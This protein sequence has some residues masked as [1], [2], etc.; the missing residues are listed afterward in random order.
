MTRE[1]SLRNIENFS[2]QE[3]FDF[4]SEK[5]L[6]QG[7]RSMIPNPYDP[8]G[9]RCSYHNE[10]CDM[11]GPKCAVGHLLSEEEHKRIDFLELNGA[12][13]GRLLDG[14]E[15]ELSNDMRAFLRLLQ[16]A[17]DMAGS[18]GAHF[19]KWFVH[20]MYLLA[21]RFDLSTEKLPADQVKQD[22]MTL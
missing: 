6:A 11:N 10:A 3:I 5:L 20:R 8:E 1:M 22:E 4:V 18:D 21:K 7:K 15:I 9:M 12:D 2:K 17:H 16:D 13:L 14:L 19:A